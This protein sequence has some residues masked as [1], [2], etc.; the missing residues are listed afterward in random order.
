MKKLYILSLFIYTHLV[1]SY[2][3]ARF[4]RITDA[5]FAQKLGDWRSVNWVDYNNDGWLDLFI[6]QG[7]QAGA[8]NSLYKNN[9]N[10]TFSAIT[11][12]PIVSDGAPSDGATWG[13]MDNDGDLDCFVVNWYGINNLFYLNNGND[14]FTQITT[15]NFVTDGGYSETAS[16]GDYDNDGFLDLYVS[17]SEGAKRNFLYHNERNGTFSKIT[18]GAPVTDAFFTRSVNWTDYDNDGDLDL[19]V[20]NEENQNDNLYRNDGGGVFTKITNVP[21][22]LDGGGTM[23]S[24]WGDMDNDGD[25]DLFLA[26]DRTGNALF[27]NDGNGNF[28]KIQSNVSET[29]NS[30][31]CQWG[32]LDNDGDLDLFVTNSFTGGPWKNFVYL[33][34]GA[35]NFEKVTT[36]AI[37]EDLGWNYGCALGDYDKDGDL[38]MA[39]AGCQN[40]SDYNRLYRNETQGKKWLEIKLVGVAT[41]KSAIGCKVRVKATIRGRSVWQMREIS[42]QSGYCGQNQLDVH[43]GLDDAA[44]VDSVAIDWLSG[45]KD[46]YS[47]IVPNRFYQITEGSPLTTGLKEAQDPSVF[48]TFSVSPNP[49]TDVVHINFEMNDSAD[50]RLDVY[51][52]SGRLVKTVLS[53]KLAKGKQ[54]F[55]LQKAQNKLE[56]GAYQLVLKAGG[57]VLSQKIIFIK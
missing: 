54:H 30:F 31:G 37:A 18:S 48:G 10:G 13:D 7:P 15:G 25:L 27:R 6:S 44:V 11:N 9:K 19:F 24:S 33:N 20:T 26:N 23:S 29:G 55:E 14:S 12:D 36:G 28:T 38:D 4:T 53:K 43:F 50:V 3:Q 51:D 46:K 32:D 52:M 16:W 21:I 1:V 42:A 45:R 17:N 2:G 56:N 57:Q 8:N 39:T 41:N 22:V 5:V 49:A 47:A 35:G 40:G 34:D